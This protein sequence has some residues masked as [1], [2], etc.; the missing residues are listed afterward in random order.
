MSAAYQDMPYLKPA[1]GLV[2]GFT[3]VKMLLGFFHW[4]LIN[5]MQSLVVVVSVVL[6]GILLSVVAG[7]CK[8]GINFLTGKKNLRKI[9]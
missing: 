3:G 7:R 6:A 5:T 9:S 4:E 1:V 2:L 8:K